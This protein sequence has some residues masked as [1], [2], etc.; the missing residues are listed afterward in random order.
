MKNE[1]KKVSVFR[2]K[3]YRQYLNDWY[4][5]AKEESRT[6]SHR[7]FAKRAGFHSTNFFMLVMQGKRN[8]TEASL[9]KMMTGLKLNKQEQDFFRNLVFLNQANT[10]EDKNF[11]YQ[12]LLQSQKFR[13]LK[14]VERQQYEYYSKWYHPV[15]RELVISK[16]FDGTSEWLAEKISPPITPA[17]AERSVELLKELGF[18]ESDGN[19][20]WKQT[21][22]IISTGP[23]LQSIVVHNYHKTLLDL[24]KEVMDKLTMKDRDTSA[25]TL[26]VKSEKLPE[27]RKKIREFRQEII[28]IASEDVEPEEVAQLNIQFFPVTRRKGGGDPDD[29]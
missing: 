19:G 11:Y 12:K 15:I 13:K 20:G 10:H 1:T 8:L 24:S 16:D 21:N 5:N 18:I 9:K 17:Q 27:I 6:F 3:D 29:K 14:P 23:E 7:A 25:M 4:H 2:Y 22:S 26:G 28:K